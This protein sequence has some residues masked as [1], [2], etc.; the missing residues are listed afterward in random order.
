MNYAE[1]SNAATRYDL[2]SPAVIRRY[3]Q[4]LSNAEFREIE[5]A[6]QHGSSPLSQGVKAGNL[7]FVSGQ[8]PKHPASGEIIN[9]DFEAQAHQVLRNVLAIIEA[10]GGTASN[11]CKVTAYL[12]DAAHFETFNRV[13]REYFD[14]KPLPARTTV[15]ARFVRPGIKVEL[16]AIAW[17]LDES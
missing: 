14:S 12:D 15:I 8:I 17:L 9:G 13:Y 1:S 16:D 3:I 6:G 5:A 2:R 11:V 4:S 7:L 10:A